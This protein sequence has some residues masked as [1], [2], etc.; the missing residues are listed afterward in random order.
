[1]TLA[2]SLGKAEER[3]STELVKYASIRN[4]IFFPG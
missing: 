3:L 4:A 2:E 1:M